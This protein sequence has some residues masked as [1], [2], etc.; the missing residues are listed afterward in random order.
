MM[1]LIFLW[2]ISSL[3]LIVA[4]L[5]YIRQLE[6]QIESLESKFAMLPQLLYCDEISLYLNN[7]SD[8]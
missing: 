5:C 7:I 3:V 6:R 8:K 2:F 4:N 1:L